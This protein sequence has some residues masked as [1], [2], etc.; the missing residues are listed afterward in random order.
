MLNTKEMEKITDAVKIIW[1]KEYPNDWE[2]DKITEVIEK[3]GF[4]W[5]THPVYSGNTITE[6]CISF[7]RKYV[8]EFF[9]EEFIDEYGR[10]YKPYF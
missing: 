8:D 9:D 1:E 10:L 3:L 6:I 7:G 5:D 2:G 4:D